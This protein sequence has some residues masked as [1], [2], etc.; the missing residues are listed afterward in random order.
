MKLKEGFITYNSGEQ[1]ILVPTG[2]Q[3]FAGLVRS[4]ESAAFIVD[5]VKEE[6]TREEMIRK[7][8]D[9]YE[10]DLDTAADGVD[11]VLRQL[12]QIGAL[13]E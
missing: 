13:D 11:R 2:G 7:L 9:H 12:R 8:M 5:S 10:I 1:Q 6:T 3:D 4:N